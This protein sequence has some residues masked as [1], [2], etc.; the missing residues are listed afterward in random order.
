MSALPTLK[1][2]A[3]DQ[4]SAAP[5]LTLD[6]AIE[7]ARSN[8]PATSELRARAQ[9]AHEGVAVARTAYIPRMDLL[10]QVNRA[11][12]NNVFG[13]VLPQ[14]VVPP[15][16]G[17]VLGTTTLDSV[18]GSAGGVLVSWQAVDF[19][20]RKAN[21]QVA[22]AQAESADATAA[23][24]EL[25]AMAAAADAFVSS[26]AA[27]EAVRAAQANVDRLQ[28]F[29]E[30]VG[31]LVRNEL[32][33]GADASRADAELAIARNQVSQSKQTAA[34]ARAL[35]AE[36]VGA[37][38]TPPTLEPGVL[39]QLPP[40]AAGDLPPIDTHPAIRA[41]VAAVES[42][43]AHER[44]LA[45]SY[46]P[47]IE[48]QSAFSG[49]GSGAEVPGQP[50]RSDGLRLD[51]PNWAAGVTVTFPVL[52][53]FA[54]GARKRAEMQNEIAERAR[55]AQAVQSVATE[56]LR[57]Q[58]LLSAATDIAG[59]TPAELA[60]A[61]D[62]ESRARARYASGL[63]SI[64]EVADAQR[65]LTQAETDDAVARLGVWRAL[66]AMAQAGGDLTPFV[67]RLHRP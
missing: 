56:R 33:P 25:D 49:R 15:I 7:L 52:D 63:A 45:R 35:L 16:S 46:A 11:T 21:V 40:A 9:A 6:R 53:G 60:A 3:Q 18:W 57:A 67:D 37:A 24:S 51:V 29:A 10:W 65:V 27:D 31:T 1:A 17:P 19:G 48:V 22:R 41:R 66:L 12:T 26:L 30:A 20:V 39:T 38:G 64:T 44:A 58:A 59:N 8:Y 28:T 50:L 2:A 47:R 36:T 62:A 42:V 4:P 14:S 13:L 43:Q 32:R 61:R 55:Q 54:I 23:L 34:V 5:P